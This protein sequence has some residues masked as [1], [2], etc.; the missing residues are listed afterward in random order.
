MTVIETRKNS[1]SY[2]KIQ[3]SGVGNRE[4]LAFKAVITSLSTFVSVLA[5]V[6]FEGLSTKLVLSYRYSD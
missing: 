4:K 6:Y 5:T 1:I 2:F 3:A